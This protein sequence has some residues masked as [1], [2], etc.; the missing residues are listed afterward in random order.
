MGIDLEGR[1]LKI[2]RTKNG[3]PITLA[4]NPNAMRAIS[5]FRL[6]GNGSG[7]VLRN[8]RG[9]PLK[10]PKTWF[11]PVVRAAEIND[12]RWH[13]CRHTFASRM[14]QKGVDL[15]TIAELLGQPQERFRQDIA[16]RAFV[17]W[18]PYGAV[19]KISNSTPIAP[20][21]LSETLADS[22]VHKVF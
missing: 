11:A 22:Y 19:S 20:S 17:D 14:R 4:L 16:M 2:S 18:R 12:F 10:W 15:A 1:M 5:I 21:P 13:D 6:W 7:R 8:V 3:D 9:E